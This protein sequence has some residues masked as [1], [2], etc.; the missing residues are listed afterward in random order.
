MGFDF[1]KWYEKNGDRLNKARRARYKSDPDYRKAVLET[2]LASR[3]RRQQAKN[4]ATGVEN[5][6]RRVDVQ[7]VWRIV[8][9]DG[10]QFFTISTLGRVLGKSIKTL[11]VWES[12]GILPETP[13][14]SAKGERLY[15]SAQ[16]LDIREKLVKE[17]MVS[18][19]GVRPKQ[20]FVV[21]KVVSDSKLLNGDTVF[22]RISSVAK[23]VGRSV[24]TILDL[25][26][27]SRFPET[28]FR[29]GGHRLYTIA[30]MESAS[31]WFDR[32][33]EDCSAKDWT[34]FYEGIMNE[35]DMLGVY[36]ARIID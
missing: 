15:T 14:R 10:E 8:E 6:A 20:D 27:K 17:G 32:L 26:R 23:V 31:K 5:S 4:E 9:K 7:N 33:D 24:A 21:R 3:R 1:K 13:H 30:M 18:Y 36:K 2:N 19:E 34:A 25:E 35:W 28:P 12:K 29:S 22:F 16:I 11:R